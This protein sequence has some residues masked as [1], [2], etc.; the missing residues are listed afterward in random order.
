MYG[1][2]LEGGGARGAYHIGAYR[3]LEELDM[4]KDITVVTGTSIGSINGALIV[5][6]DVDIAE[7][8]WRELTYSMVI[9]ADDKTIYSLI[10]NKDIRNLPRD[11]SKIVDVIVQ[12]GFDISP[13]KNL[14]ST[15]IDEEKIRKSRMR[16]GLVTVNVSDRKSL[17]LYIEEIPEGELENYL[18]ASSYLPGFKFEP[19]NGKY[20]IDGGFHDRMPVNMLK[21]TDVSKAIVI[22]TY[23]DRIDKSFLNNEDI[24]IVEPREELFEIYDFTS[25]NAEYGISLG[26]Y[27]TLKVFRGLMG[28]KYYIE[29]FNESYAYNLLTCDFEKMVRINSIL[30]YEEGSPYRNYFEKS[31]PKLFE[32]LQSKGDYTDLLI[33]AMERRLTSLNIDEFK[34]FKIEELLEMVKNTKYGRQS[35]DESIIKSFISKINPVNILNSEEIIDSVIDILFE[36]T[37]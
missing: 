36:E 3:A 24:I 29:P 6:D 7:K 10:H 8:L 26:Y 20:Y 28:Y 35:G 2:V 23:K 34:I 22:R 4:V 1:L 27:D 19:L 21:R 18:L 9:K 5:Q 16:L 37:V 17:E 31:L 11:L 12:G 15:Y 33:R 13:L 25:A 30:K 32:L 14:L